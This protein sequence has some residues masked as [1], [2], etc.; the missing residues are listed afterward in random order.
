MYTNIIHRDV[1]DSYV[2]LEYG[3]I[4]NPLD[5]T[6]TESTRKNYASMWEKINA[7]AKEHPETV[8]EETA[9]A[10]P[11]LD[12]IKSVKLAGINSAYN[13]AISSLVSTYPSTELL[14]FDKQESEARAWKTDNSVSTPLID[15]LSHGRGMDKA[16]LVSRIIKKADDFALATGYLTGQRQ[17]YEDQLDAATTVEEVES[18]VPEYV[19]PQGLSL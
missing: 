12:E 18:I 13:T 2:C 8:I 14:T 19:M 7:Y 6:L 4:P 16:E 15:A 10:D 3:H 1:D 9:P 17:R 11:T 5:K